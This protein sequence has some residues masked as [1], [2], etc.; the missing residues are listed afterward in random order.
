MLR[1]ERHQSELDLCNVSNV[2]RS[3]FNILTGKELRLGLEIL[4][5]VVVVGRRLRSR[6]SNSTTNT[7]DHGTKSKRFVQ[8][9]KKC[10]GTDEKEYLE[11]EHGASG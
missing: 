2:S 9:D 4:G 3:L 7:T 1:M 11:C 8:H 10:D 5:D 6:R